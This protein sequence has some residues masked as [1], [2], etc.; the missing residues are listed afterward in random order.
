MMLVLIKFTYSHLNITYFT[1]YTQMTFL[2]CKPSGRSEDKA[3][4]P[5]GQFLF[6]D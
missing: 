5:I 4:Y 3:F 2:Q 1:V 6:L